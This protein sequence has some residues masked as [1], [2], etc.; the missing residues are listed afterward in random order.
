M[1]VL[2]LGE[3]IPKRSEVKNYFQKLK[4]ALNGRF[5]YD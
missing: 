3:M 2:Q 1:G 4:S 5:F